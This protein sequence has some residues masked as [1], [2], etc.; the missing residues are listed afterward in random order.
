MHLP[1][2]SQMEGAKEKIIL[3]IGG[4]RYE[5]YSSTLWTFPGTK[6]YSLTDPQASSVYDYD[7]ATKE[8]FF[9][10]S[11]DIFSYVLNYYRTKHFHC[12]IEFCRSV[13][14]EELAFWEINETQLPSCC[15]LKLNNQEVQP[16]EFNNW[17]ENE[18]ADDQCLIVQTER[19][20]TRWQ[21][22]IWSM[23]EKPF[24]SFSAK[25]MN[26]A[27]VLWDYWNGSMKN[28]NGFIALLSIL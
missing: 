12:P 11:A 2:P 13:L 14:E 8:F 26:T 4:V 6:L 25:V 9:D 10:R 20:D 28:D 7:P 18:P 15:W 21:S 24:S 19:R 27:C 17:D 3:N 1:P 5:T 16:E 22:K 23:F